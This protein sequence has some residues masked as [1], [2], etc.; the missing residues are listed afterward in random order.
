[1]AP[2]LD[3]IA[4]ALAVFTIAALLSTSAFSAGS[5]A[6]VHAY[7]MVLL[8]GTPVAS[9]LANASLLTTRP[10]TAYRFTDAESSEQ[11]G[12]LG[13]VMLEFE[14]GARF[15][16]R[17][18]NTTVG[19]SYAHAADLAFGAFDLNCTSGARVDEAG[20]AAVPVAGS[21]T[22]DFN[23]TDLD[24]EA[25]ALL[26]G[27]SLLADSEFVQARFP[28]LGWHKGFFIV[29]RTW[30]AYRNMLDNNRGTHTAFLGSAAVPTHYY[31]NGRDWP[32]ARENLPRF[33]FELPPWIE[34][35]R[36][37]LLVAFHA[38]LLSFLNFKIEVWHH[39]EH[40]PMSGEL[41]WCGETDRVARRGEPV[42]E[43]RCEATTLYGE[44]PSPG[45]FVSIVALGP[46]GSRFK[47]LLLSEVMLTVERQHPPPSPPP[48]P[49]PPPPS[50]SPPPPSP[51]PPPYPPPFIPTFIFVDILVWIDRPTVQE[52][53]DKGE[54][55]C[56]ETAIDRLRQ[57][58]HDK[59]RVVPT[60]ISKAEY[61][62]FDYLP[63]GGVKPYDTLTDRVVGAP[64]SK[65][66]EVHNYRFDDFHAGF[67]L[68]SESDGDSGINGRCHR[69]SSFLFTRPVTRDTF[70]KCFS[71]KNSEVVLH[72]L[73]H[74]LGLPHGLKHD[75]S[76][77]YGD[78]TIMGSR[79]YDS[80]AG[81]SASMLHVLGL[82]PDS[83]IMYLD[84]IPAS[85]LEYDVQRAYSYQGAKFEGHYYAVVCPLGLQVDTL[86]SA[87][88]NRCVNSDAR[89]LWIEQLEEYHVQ[90]R[91]V[92]RGSGYP[93]FERWFNINRGVTADVSQR[94]P[95]VQLCVH[96]KQIGNEAE[97]STVR[98][99]PRTASGC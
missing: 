51:P 73:G 62:L 29:W 87:P 3:R 81:F 64:S 25:D 54:V 7:A 15:A 72:E 11:F 14:A 22:L 1:M 85:K 69:Y 36:V 13:A 6:V 38:G 8:D 20:Y 83:K 23:R 99:Y 16:Y 33:T 61:P 60:Y 43:F 42:D 9:P 59:V 4:M 39:R 57:F 47:L 80:N 24:R 19:C 10:A 82:I 77:E 86:T 63:G 30:G 84:G 92:C 98:V 94:H 27:V 34:A 90:I 12:S 70:L 31:H 50:P 89:Q 32:G 48:P 26:S 37:R 93:K 66:F 17:Y 56:F 91:L 53:R 49:P 79:G 46:I 28:A 21:A 41:V 96:N 97:I 2:R 95:S 75:A 65:L 76:D 58:T 45:G 40:S 44:V 78:S 88:D 5:T 18:E 68:M 35:G 71:G 74:L 67:M 55:E 52:A